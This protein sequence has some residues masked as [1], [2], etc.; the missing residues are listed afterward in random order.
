MRRQEKGNDMKKD[1]GASVT[2]VAGASK[3][4]RQTRREFLIKTGAGALA[5]GA[6]PLRGWAAAP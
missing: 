2:D 4:K 6:V 1:R 5:F 3:K